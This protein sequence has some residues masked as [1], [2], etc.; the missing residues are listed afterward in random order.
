MDA[1]WTCSTTKAQK[2]TPPPSAPDTDQMVIDTGPN[3]SVT[4]MTPD[5]ARDFSL[6]LLELVMPDIMYN[7]MPWPEE[8][9]MKVTMERYGRV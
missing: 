2:D 3:E 9:F 4:N 6:I 7:G 5:I 8:D 1:L